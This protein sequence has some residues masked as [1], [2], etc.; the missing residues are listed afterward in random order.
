MDWIQPYSTPSARLPI[1]RNHIHRSPY[2]EWKP[3]LKMKEQCI[4]FF[5]LPIPCASF[6]SHPTPQRHTQEQTGIVR[7]EAWNPKKVWPTDRDWPRKF[8]DRAFLQNAP[9]VN[10]SMERESTKHWWCQ[11]MEHHQGMFSL[12]PTQLHHH[13]WRIQG[14]ITI[15]ERND[16]PVHKHL[17]IGGFGAMIGGPDNLVWGWVWYQYSTCVVCCVFGISYV[18]SVKWFNSIPSVWYV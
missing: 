1:H 11:S 9:I 18:E 15:G 8:N 14:T 12:P 2:C 17:Q 5:T 13:H 3:Q 7:Q 6:S 10:L 4:T 16:L